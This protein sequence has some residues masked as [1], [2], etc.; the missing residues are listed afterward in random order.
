VGAGRARQRPANTGV[1]R[2][3]MAVMLAPRPAWTQ[4][5]IKRRVSTIIA[6][7]ADSRWE[8]ASSRPSANHG[9][10]KTRTA[11]PACK[12]RDLCIEVVHGAHLAV[13]VSGCTIYLVMALVS[14]NSLADMVESLGLAPA[15]HYTVTPYAH[16]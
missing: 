15:I 4:L 7:S 6:Q 8:F 5:S 16:V 3:S 13:G 9:S 1:R 11:G 2:S 12:V 10:V 14:Q